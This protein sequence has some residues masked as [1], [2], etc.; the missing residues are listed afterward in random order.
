MNQYLIA[1]CY[2]FTTVLL[3]LAFFIIRAVPSGSPLNIDLYCDNMIISLA[4]YNLAELRYCSNATKETLEEPVDEDWNNNWNDNEDQDNNEG[5]NHADDWIPGLGNQPQLNTPEWID[6]VF[7]YI[8]LNQIKEIAGRLFAQ[9]FQSNYKAEHGIP[10]RVV[11]P[12]PSIP[13]LEEKPVEEAQGQWEIGSNN[14]ISGF[15]HFE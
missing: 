1:F 6:W 11:T 12:E 3:F 13:E 15:G 14:E 2:L 10:Y 5:W 9:N 4:I 7:T 8:S